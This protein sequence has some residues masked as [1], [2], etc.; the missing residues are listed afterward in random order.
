MTIQARIFRLAAKHKMARW[1]Y[2]HAPMRF[3][4]WIV[5]NLVSD[6]D[7]KTTTGNLAELLAKLKPVEIE[8]RF[9]K[10]SEE[11]GEE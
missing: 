11:V 7:M 4:E 10:D 2:N 6:D 5:C 1:F 8:V 3:R 9:Y